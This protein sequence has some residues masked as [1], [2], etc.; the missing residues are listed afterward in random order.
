MLS[1]DD[2]DPAGDQYAGQAVDRIL[3]SAVRL[4]VSDVHLME[5][6]ND[7]QLRF[8]IDGKLIDMPAV[9]SGLNTSLMSRIKAMARL[10]T[11]RKD[12]PQDGRMLVTGESDRR[13]EMRVSTLPTL[14]GERVVIRLSYPKSAPW[15]PADLGLAGDVLEHLQT[16]LSRS[17]GLI[18]VCGPAGSGKTTTAY[19]GLRSLLQGDRPRSV[20]TL[21]DPIECELPGAAQ[22]QI[23]PDSEYDW[24]SGLK[25]ILR[26]DPEVLMIGEIRDSQTASVAFQAG[27]AGQLVLSTLHARSTVDAIQRLVD[28]GVPYQHLRSGL[29]MLMC[30]RLLPKLCRCQQQPEQDAESC[31][32]CG[33]SATAGRLV[34][35]EVFP[36]I[37]GTLA[38]AL[39]EG[40]DADRLQAAALSLKMTP[41]SQLTA[42]A[43]EQNLVAAAD[44]AVEF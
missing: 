26:Q 25:A 14:H 29:S 2:L 30:Q 33:G 16:A 9:P 8:R 11:Y 22:S 17:S 7:L 27:M 28:M 21:E 32:V 38:Q 44:A 18:L 12:I 42:V 19:A 4:G 15:L 13:L 40:T 35:A 23:N 20:V 37:E 39:A 24:L 1:F 41:L 34:I 36:C 3:Q 5:R 10:I 31:E 6:E 43:V